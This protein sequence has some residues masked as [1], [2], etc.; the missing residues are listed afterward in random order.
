M[1]AEGTST[2]VRRGPTGGWA[3][4]GPKCTLDNY[5]GPGA[6]F[7]SKDRY[8]K[9]LQMPKTSDFESFWVSTN[10]H[11]C[12]SDSKH[13]LHYT[14]SFKKATSSDGRRLYR[15]HR[16][17][18]WRWEQPFFDYYNASLPGSYPDW[19]RRARIQPERFDASALKWA[20]WRLDS[21]SNLIT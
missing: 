21:A 5:G 19:R 14:Q 3:G 20:K 13:I 11:L 15:G 6:G 10:C 2:P 17:Q 9:K 12:L 1:G 16:R 4:R 7:C 18:P 8:W